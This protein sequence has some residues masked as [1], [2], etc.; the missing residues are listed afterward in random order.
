[1]VTHAHEREAALRNDA[2][3]G[4]VRRRLPSDES[5]SSQSRD[6]YP[7]RRRDD[8]HQWERGLVR[9]D[10]DEAA[11]WLQPLPRSPEGMDHAPDRDSSQRPAEDG[12]VERSAANRQVLDGADAKRDIAYAKRGLLIERILDARSIRVDSQHRSGGWRVLEGEPAIA[13]AD[14]EDAPPSQ[15][16]ETL[17][18]TELHPVRRIR[19]DVEGCSHRSDGTV[20]RA[21]AR[22]GRPYGAPQRALPVRVRP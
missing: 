21:R 19:R 6:G 16:R 18:Q 13:A 1:M 17:D 4:G 7:S 2:L 8:G 3:Q 11:A 14:L 20:A 5:R 9:P 12:N 15:R 22:P 10:A